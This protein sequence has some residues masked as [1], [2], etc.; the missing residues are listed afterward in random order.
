[1]V[2]AG[3]PMPRMTLTTIAALM[4]LGVWM[5]ATD[6]SVREEPGPAEPGGTGRARSAGQSA[7]PGG[8]GADGGFDPCVT[9]GGDVGRRLPPLHCVQ[10]FP[11]AEFAGASGRVELGRVPGP[12]GVSVSRDGHH[13]YELTFVVDGLPDAS[14]LGASATYVA[15]VTNPLLDPVVKLGEVGN[16]RLRLGR[17]VLNK[18]TVWI[19]LEPSDDTAQREGRLVLRGRSPSSV[20]EAHDLL[21]L[22]PT[23][24]MPTRPAPAEGAHAHAGGGAGWS[25]PPMHPAVPM[26]PGLRGLTPGVTPYLP[27]VVDLERLPEARPRQLVRLGDGGTLDLEAGMVRRTIG[28]RTLAMYGFNGQYPGPLIQVPEKATIF[29]NFTNHTELPTTIHWHGVRLDNRYDGVPGVTQDPVN[30]GDTFRYRIFFRDAGIYW[31]H[32]HHREDI[33]Q[34]LGLYGNMLVESPRADYFGP[35]HR[36]AVLM[37]DDLLL[38]EA[39]LVPFGTE[40]S[41]YALMGRFGNVLLINGEPDYELEVERGEIVRFFFTNVSNT[42]TF[43]VSFDG[44]PVRGV[45]CRTCR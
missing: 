18:F 33:Q 13:R 15:W 30:P 21:T 31:Y 7:E 4:S 6:R 38:G 11:T 22:A 5:S 44:T 37:L 19:S 2:V 17:V 24:V 12:F 10:L 43:N 34:E 23:A 20:M 41:N 8:A 45:R 29:V 25:M 3:V 42:R 1:M 32:P 28:S 40:A 35:A 9:S 36:E 39:G 26:L 27:A 14:T 16:G